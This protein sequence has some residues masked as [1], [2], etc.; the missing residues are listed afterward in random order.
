MLKRFLSIALVLFMMLGIFSFTASAAYKIGDPLGDIVYSDIV[1]YING[2]TI[3]TSIKNGM[4]MVVV[5]DL[6]N[7][8]FDVVWNGV[9]KTLNVKP[10]AA[11]KITP[12]PVEKNTKPVG[13]FKCK[14]VYTDIKTYLSGKLVESFAISGV[15]LIDFELLADYGKLTWDGK[16]RTIKLTTGTTPIPAPA[17][18]VTLAM[19]EKAAKDAGYKTRTIDWFSPLKFDVAPVAGIFVE[20]SKDYSSGATAGGTAGDVGIY[21]FKDKADADAYVKNHKSDNIPLQNGKFVA[22]L[23][24]SKMFPTHDVDI[25]AVFEKLLQGKSK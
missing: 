22:M 2:N 7:Y 9:A 4:T 1:A 13:E 5:E 10:N 16:A 6:S 17:T 18:D 8:G 23:Y 11:K 25:K 20:Y 24:T 12:L 19:I 3:P 15:T 14:Y 21:E